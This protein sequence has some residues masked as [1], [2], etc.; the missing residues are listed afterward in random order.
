MRGNRIGVVDWVMLALALVSVAMLVYETWGPVTPEQREQILL[1][2]L[3]I[4]AIFAI[5]FTMRWIR[6]PR[7]KT[8]P[9][10]NWYELLGMVPVAHPAVRGFRLF[11]II[12]IVVILSRFGRAADRAFGEEFT[13]RVVRRF[14]D[15]IAD[16]VA[17]AVTLRVL[18]ETGDVL[19]KGTYAQNLADALERRGDEMLD[20]AVEKIKADEK[21]GAVRH[22][23]FFDQVVM[24]SARVSQRIVIDLLRDDR[25]EAIIRDIIRLNVAQIQAAVKQREAGRALAAA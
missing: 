11:R 10:R 15:I 24:T 4:I 7:P 3:V 22:I 16:A 1:A 25:M 12:R 6:D 21:V 19:Q 2:D 18:E 9:L 20:I 23:P 8:F 5:E 14:K 13:Y 17:G